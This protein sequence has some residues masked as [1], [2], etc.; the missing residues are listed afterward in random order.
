MLT[1]GSG[2]RI[3]SD[4]QSVL[5][6]AVSHAEALFFATRLY[7]VRQD[8][9]SFLELNQRAVEI[10]GMSKE[11]RFAV[12]SDFGRA[13][14]QDTCA[15][16]AHSIGCCSDLVYLEAKVMYAASRVLFEE[17]RYRGALPKRVEKLNLCVR[18]FD[19]D[20]SHAVL[21]QILR[22]RNAGSKR[23]IPVCSGR[24]VRYGDGDM[25][26]GSK[27]GRLQ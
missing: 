12:R 1:N 25:I 5:P 15:S 8:M 6:A 4:L 14:A 2:L 13:V 3:F 22:S 27:H 21:R 11:H 16:G 23:S 20:D 26:E 10:L 17:A 18:Q 24:K 19:E 7:P 9:G